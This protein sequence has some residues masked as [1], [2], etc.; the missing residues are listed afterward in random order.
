MSVSIEVLGCT[1]E[2]E[3][4]KGLEAM[5]LFQRAAALAP[6]IGWFESDALISRANSV[7]ALAGHKDGFPVALETLRG[8]KVDG[9]EVTKESF[10]TLF[11]RPG[12]YL[13]PF[14]AAIRIWL[15]SGFLSVPA[16]S[17]DGQ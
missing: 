8:W 17:R 1:F 15:E 14:S 6:A 5:A 4:P 9:V 2:G 11:Q 16:I 12:Y 10:L 3:L 13:V 7:A